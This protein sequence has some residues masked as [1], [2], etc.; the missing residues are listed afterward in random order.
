MKNG[1]PPATRNP[2]CSD[3]EVVRLKNRDDQHVL[4][5][6]TRCYPSTYLGASQKSFVFTL[7]TEHEAT[8]K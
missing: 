3:H 5:S 4:S 1:T 8:I 2:C 7:L 6:V